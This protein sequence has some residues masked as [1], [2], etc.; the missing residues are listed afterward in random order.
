[1]MAR[2]LAWLRAIFAAPTEPEQEQLRASPDCLDLIKFFEG[3]RLS[4]YLDPV[5][6]LTIG[7]GDTENVRP[8][9]VITQQEADARL[10]NRVVRD[11]EPAVHAAIGVPIRQHEFDAMVSLA[12]NIG[13]YAFATSTLAKK[14]NA[15][16]IVGTSLQFLRWDKAGGVSLLGL[17]RRRAAEKALFDGRSLD[18]ALQIGQATP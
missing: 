17:R 18:E 5:G 1:M 13:A 10:R 14:F 7:Y 8:G 16:D 15:G 2:L 3:C 6:V 4:A 11:F 9:M 12:Y